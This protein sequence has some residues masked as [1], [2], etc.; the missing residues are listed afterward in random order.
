MK[1]P[2]RTFLGTLAVSP[3]GAA[4]AHEVPAPAPV[5]TS[6]AE[7]LLAA[8]RAR[9]GH[10]LAPGDVEEVGK[11]IAYLLRAGEK[12]RAH[13][14]ANGEAPVGSFEARPAELRMARRRAT[15]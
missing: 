11:G 10:H 6:M 8:A 7:G 2:R 4:A 12:L 5:E 13:P 14:L 3:L 1:A 9:F 15:P